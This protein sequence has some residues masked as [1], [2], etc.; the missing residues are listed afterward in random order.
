MLSLVTFVGEIDHSTEDR[1]D[2]QDEK[3]VR[4]FWK[5]EFEQGCSQNNDNDHPE[6]DANLIVV[7]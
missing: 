7:R 2:Q 6:Q 4:A 3:E 1:Q 5:D